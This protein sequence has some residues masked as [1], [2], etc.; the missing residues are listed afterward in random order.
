MWRR[1]IRGGFREEVLR[2]IGI[3]RSWNRE[4][5]RVRMDWFS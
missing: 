1:K 3:L 4:F 2:R 5:F